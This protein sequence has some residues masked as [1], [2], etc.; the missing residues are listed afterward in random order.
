MKIETSAAVHPIRHTANG[1]ALCRWCSQPTKHY[2]VFICDARIRHGVCLA[3]ER[4]RFD[5]KFLADCGIAVDAACGVVYIEIEMRG[6]AVR[7]ARK[8]RTLRRR[9]SLMGER[10]AS[11]RGEIDLG[12]IFFKDGGDLR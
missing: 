9:K 7:K 6:E 1:T 10:R 3:E 8:L 5:R 2:T 11:G 12:E 4:E